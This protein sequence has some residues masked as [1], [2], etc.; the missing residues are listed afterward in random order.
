MIWWFVAG[1]ALIWAVL[2]FFGLYFSHEED[3][4]EPG[5]LE[6]EIR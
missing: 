1:G 3:P 6:N 5:S 4:P 2:I